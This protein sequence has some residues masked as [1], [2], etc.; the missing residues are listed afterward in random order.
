MAS[1]LPIPSSSSVISVSPS[2]IVANS[3]SLSPRSIVSSSAFLTSVNHHR[4]LTSVSLRGSF[5]YHR[6]RGKKTFC[7]GAGDVVE[8]DPLPVLSSIDV[9]PLKLKLLNAVAGLNKGFAA[10]KEDLKIVES[11]AEKLE[12][13]GEPVDLTCNIDMIQGR[14]KLIYSSAFSSGTLGGSRPGPPTGRLLPITLGKVFQRIDV[15]SKDFDNIVEVE[16]GTPWPLPKVEATATL[17]HKFELIGSSKIKIAFVKTTVNPTGNLAQ[18][19]PIE[20]PRLPD[21]LK[22]PS[23]ESGEGEF[24]VTYLDVDTRITRGDRGELRIFVIS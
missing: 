17:A 16:F 9:A 6:R 20:L 5:E 12:S 8:M 3:S 7:T 2:S 21:G 14:W 22:P 18:I 4:H 24:D 10:N 23:S 15:L 11:I 13:V 1:I 19:P